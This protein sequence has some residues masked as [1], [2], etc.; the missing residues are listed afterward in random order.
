MHVEILNKDAVKRYGSS[1]TITCANTQSGHLRLSRRSHVYFYTHAL[2]MLFLHT[3]LKALSV[4]IVARL[5]PNAR[6]HGFNS[7][8]SKW[9]ALELDGDYKLMATM[10]SVDQMV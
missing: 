7:H 6:G 10:F 1:E 3:P 2:K 9:R 5:Q 8:P 4:G